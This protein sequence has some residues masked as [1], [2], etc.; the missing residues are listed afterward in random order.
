MLSVDRARKIL[1]DEYISMSDEDIQKFID[2][3]KEVC[4]VVVAGYIQVKSESLKD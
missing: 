3:L 1:W 2:M 4:S